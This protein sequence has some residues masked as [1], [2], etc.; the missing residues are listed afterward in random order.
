MALQASV[1]Y[2]GLLNITYPLQGQVISSHVRLAGRAVVPDPAN[3]PAGTQWLIDRL[4][5]ADAAQVLNGHALF[6]KRYYLDTLTYYVDG[7]PF[8]EVSYIDDEVGGHVFGNDYLNTV[9]DGTEIAAGPHRFTIVARFISHQNPGVELFDVVDLDLSYDATAIS[10]AGYLDRITPSQFTGEVDVRIT[11][12]MLD[13]VLTQRTEGA[14]K[15]DIDQLANLYD[16]DNAPAGLLPYLAKTVGYDYFAGLIAS[17]GALREELRFLPEWQKSAGTEG[18]IQSLLR[19]LLLTGTITPLYLDVVSNYLVE[20]VKNRH[21]YTDELRIEDRTRDARFALPLTHGTAFVPATVNLSVALDDGTVVFQAIW[22]AAN[23][24]LTTILFE[25]TIPWLERGDGSHAL[26][27]DVQEILADNAR[28]GITVVFD[29]AMR[30]VATL[31]VT[32]A[33]QYDV[34]SRPRRNTRLSEFFDARIE[35]AARP[36]TFEASDYLHVFEIIKRSKPFH[37]KLRHITFPAK[38]AD[39]YHVNAFSLSSTGLLSNLDRIR[40]AGIK[41]TE[42]QLNNPI[43]EQ[44][45]L[46]QF[47]RL[48]DGFLFTWERDCNLFENRF[49]IF[50]DL[51]IDPRD[52]DEEFKT[53]LRD[54]LVARGHA[55]WVHNDALYATPRERRRWLRRVDLRILNFTTP[56]AAKVLEG[57]LAHFH[58]LRFD[59]V[60]SPAVQEFRDLMFELDDPAAFSPA[61]GVDLH[62]EVLSDPS[63]RN[64]FSLRWEGG[65]SVV[66]TDHPSGATSTV[67]WDVDGTDEKVLLQTEAWGSATL[68]VVRFRD[69]AQLAAFRVARPNLDNYPFEV[70]GSPDPMKWYAVWDVEGDFYATPV[71][72]SATFDFVWANHQGTTCCENDAE[73]SSAAPGPVSFSKSLGVVYQ[74]A[75]VVVTV[76]NVETGDDVARYR[77]VGAYWV[78]ELEHAD[79]VV[80]L[81]PA[82]GVGWSAAMSVDGTIEYVGAAD[83]Y[84]FAL[85]ACSTK[86]G[87]ALVMTPSMGLSDDYKVHVHAHDGWFG[88]IDDGAVFFAPYDLNARAMI[89]HRHDQAQETIA[90]D[91]FRFRDGELQAGLTMTVTMPFAS[92]AQFTYD[93]DSYDGNRFYDAAPVADQAVTIHHFPKRLVVTTED[94]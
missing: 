38:S 71:H 4:E 24:R 70:G 60:V 3:L 40:D 85:R 8:R 80:T 76:T 50:H 42:V 11:N 27:G 43:Q 34:D 53:Q 91:D 32:V 77:W 44:V 93:T 65:S 90:E 92:A 16:V 49:G 87:D 35:S 41:P 68:T 57:Q 81:D 79:L 73:V 89:W 94:A 54:D 45:S 55:V 64:G 7:R 14:L 13:Y 17:Q 83:S 51:D 19:P 56:P 61:G 28:R 15:Y 59:E 1:Q 75:D 29:Q 2:P 52:Q 78:A 25:E 88:I 6:G 72:L 10:I 23:L 69:D 37:T 30:V 9:Y 58:T 12:A 66:R 86:V 47:N 18:S 84:T 62:V 26:A 82:A 46:T 21:R 39:A 20:G 63:V 5:P 74:N 31:R 22:D 33:Y 67:P 48:C 36:N